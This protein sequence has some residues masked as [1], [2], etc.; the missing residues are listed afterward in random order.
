[1][2]FYLSIGLTK[3]GDNTFYPIEPNTKSGCIVDPS[4]PKLYAPKQLL[5]GDMTR[6]TRVFPCTKHITG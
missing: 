2:H 4:I 6:F 5:L 3:M 1:M